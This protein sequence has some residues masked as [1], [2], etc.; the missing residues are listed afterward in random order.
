MR[1]TDE[2]VEVALAAYVRARGTYEREV[3]A[4]GDDIRA[5]LEAALSHA[6]GQEGEKKVD[7]IAE[8]HHDYWVVR[9]LCAETPRFYSIRKSDGQMLELPHKDSPFVPFPAQPTA[10]A[11]V[12]RDS[13]LSRGVPE[14]TKRLDWLTEPDAIDRHVSQCLNGEWCA[15]DDVVSAHYGATPREAIDAAIAAQRKEGE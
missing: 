15:Q 5:A 1:V 2:M 13:A 10:S 6:A 4:D 11:E 9:V 3:P 8:N 12:G 14:D 7:W